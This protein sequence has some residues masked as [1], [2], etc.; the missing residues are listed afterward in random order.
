[1]QR[2]TGSAAQKLPGHSIGIPPEVG[3]LAA[4]WYLAGTVVP[5]HSALVLSPGVPERVGILW[6]QYPLLTN[7]FETTITIKAKRPSMRSAKEG[8]FAFWYV[9][10]NGTAA[11]HNIT[12]EHAENQDEMV[13]GAWLP[14]FE[15]AGMDLFGYRRRY[16]GLGVFFVDEDSPSV[17]VIPNDG[18]KDIAL[19][20]EVPTYDAVKFDF[21]NSDEFKVHITITPDSAKVALPGGTLDV[22][23]T[24]KAGGYIGITSFGGKMLD[25]SKPKT[26]P[27]VEM[28]G[29]EVTNQ[30]A[31]AKGEETH[32]SPPPLPSLSPDEKADILAEA[33]S[34]KDHR[35]ESDAIKDLTNMVFKLVVETQPM[36]TQM[37]KAI[38]TLGKRIA[39]ME[40]S[41]AEL[42]VE[43]DKKT[44]HKLGEEFD[45]IKEELTSLS[46][47][48]VKESKERHHK[49][50]TLHADI[51]DVHKT[52]QSSDNID[53][54]LD[55][56]T[57][58]NSK[59][60]DQLTSEHQKMFGVS[61]AAIG[62]IIIAGLSLYNKFRCWEKKHVL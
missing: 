27:R 26:G 23:G 5:S 25:P 61:I 6:S 51:A 48:A 44:G 55:K 13:S 52:A 16:N 58:S 54:H 29:L 42:K 17:S 46:T 14:E 8:G 56:L 60:L 50:E 43:L 57:E 59:V 32:A 10:E 53:K 38:D 39:A 7:S 15:K 20:R 62:F 37:S 2:W 4:D 1:M 30:D 21:F 18:T 36:R 41:F 24:F 28:K 35:A 45:A 34:Y 47:A 31:S 22:K 11:H 40:T 49:L 12:F 9:Y 19:G 33:S 3:L